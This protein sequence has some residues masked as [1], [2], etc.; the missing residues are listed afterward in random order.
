[1][2]AAAADMITT[3]TAGNNEIS[4]VSQ[5][6]PTTADENRIRQHRTPQRIPKQKQ[7]SSDKISYQGKHSKGTEIEAIIA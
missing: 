7:V 3:Q 6:V 2:A 1:M 4:G 5:A